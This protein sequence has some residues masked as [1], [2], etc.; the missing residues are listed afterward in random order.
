MM[1]APK[2]ADVAGDHGAL[3]L[4]AVVEADGAVAALLVQLSALHTEGGGGVRYVRALPF[5]FIEVVS[6]CRCE[7]L[8]AG[9][10]GGEAG[11]IG[12]S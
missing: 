4:A 6:A 7:P 10:C 2:V 9:Y 5:F 3:L 11:V 8:W 1:R 12:V